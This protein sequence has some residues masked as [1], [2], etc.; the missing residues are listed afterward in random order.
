MS[1]VTILNGTEQVAT[2]SFGAAVD[3]L[4]NNYNKNHKAFY[5][6]ECIF[7]C[8]IDHERTPDAIADRMGCYL[9][10]E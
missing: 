6:S 5:G 9:S 2:I 8:A 3:F 7:D 1:N 10:A 4:A